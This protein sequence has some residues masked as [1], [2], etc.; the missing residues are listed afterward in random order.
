MIGCSYLALDLPRLVAMVQSW[1]RHMEKS[2][3]YQRIMFFFV[4]FPRCSI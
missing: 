2:A 4:R 1:R 3:R